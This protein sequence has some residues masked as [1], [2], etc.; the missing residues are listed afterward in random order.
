[1]KRP[2]LK[3]RGMEEAEDS[4]FKRQENIFNKIIEENSPNL[5][6]KR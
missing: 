2:S 4:Q 6:K 1:M 3:I 5:K